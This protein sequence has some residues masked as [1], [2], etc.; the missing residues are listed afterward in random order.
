MGERGN[1]AKEENK[2]DNVRVL[3]QVAHSIQNEIE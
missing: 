3:S 1:K 2:K